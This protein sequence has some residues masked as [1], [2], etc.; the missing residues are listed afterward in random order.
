M[1]YCILFYCILVPQIFKKAFWK[2]SGI[3]S[4]LQKLWTCAFY[5]TVKNECPKTEKNPRPINLETYDTF[6]HNS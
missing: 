4:F 2:L 5:A 1:V 6:C 3:F